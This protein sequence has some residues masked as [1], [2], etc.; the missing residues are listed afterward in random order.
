MEHAVA[1][2]KA[3]VKSLSDLNNFSV[4][5]N[6]QDLPSLAFPFGN[7]DA[8]W[9]DIARR[10]LTERLVILKAK[11]GTIEDLLDELEHSITRGNSGAVD[12]HCEWIIYR[13]L[14]ELY[15]AGK[16]K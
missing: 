16:A 1:V 13:R 6:I 14:Y 7:A 10:V 11:N 2:K 12:R 8:I 9:H 3:V 15:E 4:F 5:N